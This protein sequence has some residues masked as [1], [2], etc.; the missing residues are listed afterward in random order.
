MQTVISGSP[1]FTVA[2]DRGNRKFAVPLDALRRTLVV[3]QREGAAGLPRHPRPHPVLL[4]GLHQ[5]HQT[6]QQENA[7]SLQE[8]QGTA[9]PPGAAGGRAQVRDGPLLPNDA[10]V[11]TGRFEGRHRQGYDFEVPPVDFGAR[12]P[13]RPGAAVQVGGARRSQPVQGEIGVAGEAPR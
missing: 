1:L 4:P 5:R 13:L 11:I 2:T 6:L 9:D 12:R 8:M 7:D 10:G 3:R